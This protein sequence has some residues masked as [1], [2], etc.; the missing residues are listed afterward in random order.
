[1]NR[2]KYQTQHEHG[3]ASTYNRLFYGY[4]TVETNVKNQQFVDLEL[5]K[6]DL[7]NAFY[8]RPGERVMM[9]T[10]GCGIWNLL[11][12]PFDDLTRQSVVDE[13]QKVI[14]GEPRVQANSIA[15][16]AFDQGIQIQIDLF[17]VPFNVVETFSLNFDRRTAESF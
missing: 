4:S 2:Y 10:W 13:V 6:R 11:Y 1:L 16:N 8:T 7:L 3:M 17:Y 9:P 14:N 5:V 12:E 15:V